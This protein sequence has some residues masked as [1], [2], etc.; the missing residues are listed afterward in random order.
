ME[1]RNT[2]SIWFFIGSLLLFYGVLITAY[3]VYRLFSPTATTTVLANLH[4]DIWWGG[5]LVLIGA[6][7]CIKFPPGKA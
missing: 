3:G 2:I 4:P 7:Y 1:Q 5:F 6:L